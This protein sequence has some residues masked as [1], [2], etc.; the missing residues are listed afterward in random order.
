M[1]KNILFLLLLLT[2]SAFSQQIVGRQPLLG[3]QINQS[4]LLSQELELFLLFSEGSGGIVYD[5]TYNRRNGTLTNMDPATDWVAGRDGWALNFDATEGEYLALPSGVTVLTAG[6]PYTI[7]WW[8]KINADTDEFPARF[9]LEVAGDADQYSVLRSTNT[10]YLPLNIG[11]D[12]DGVGA[13]HKNPTGAPS[14]AS[15]IGI[16]R[17]WVITGAD[18]VSTNSAD[19]S[20]YV[21]GVLYATEDGG[22]LSNLSGSNR[23]G[24]DGTDNGA[25]CQMADIRIYKRKLTESDVQSLFISQYAMFEQPPGRILAA[26]AE[27]RSRFIWIN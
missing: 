17:H 4:Y 3:T 2:S 21:D 6:V 13:N 9:V 1:R 24:Y 26:A 11:M 10:S 23:I 20:F 25:N 7:S 5:I 27:A 14:I 15:S 18:P 22:P 12:N 8:E 19:H 16:W